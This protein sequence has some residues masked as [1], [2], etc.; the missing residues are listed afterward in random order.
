M[1]ELD[2]YDR[3]ILSLLQSNAMLTTKEIAERI[4]LTTTPVFERI[5]RLEKD[6]YINGYVALLDKGKLGKSLVAFCDVSLKEHSKDYLKQFEQEVARLEQ[7]MECYHIA[8]MYDYLL[9]VVV[10][11]MEAYQSFIVNTLAALDNIGRVQSSFVMTE[12]KHTTA[13]QL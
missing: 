6:G 10:E 13:L 7:V 5:R 2:P 1:P 9:K 12:I 4:N 11:N 3:Q 8:G